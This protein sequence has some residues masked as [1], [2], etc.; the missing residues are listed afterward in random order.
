MKITPADVG[1]KVVLRN[2]G[3]DVL[4]EVKINHCATP[5][6]VYWID[7]RFKERTLDPTDII[8]FAD[9]PEVKQEPGEALKSIEKAANQLGLSSKEFY[10]EVNKPIKTLRDE[11]AMAALTGVMASPHTIAAKELGLDKLSDGFAQIAYE[12]ADAMLKA[13]GVK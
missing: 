13:R 6:R 9:E 4:T 1:R 3:F 2:G 12:V 5:N 11:F 7:G 8:A 10:Q